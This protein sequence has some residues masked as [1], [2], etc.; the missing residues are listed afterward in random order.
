MTSLAVAIALQART[1][2]S[3]FPKKVLFPIK[4]TPLIIH[5][6]SRL[7]GLNLPIYVLTSDD[8][9]DDDLV[10]LLAKNSVDFF[11]GNLSNV[12]NRFNSFLLTTNYSHVFRIS[13]D[14]PLIHPAL[15][16]QAL[17]LA[18]KENNFDLI[19]NVL[20]RSF[21]KG[22]S[23]ELISRGAL[24]L[25][26]QRTSE[27]KDLEHVTSFFYRNVEK[28]KVINFASDSNLAFWNLCIDT[29][30]D[31]E[32]LNTIMEI[33]LSKPNSDVFWSDWDKFVSVLEAFRPV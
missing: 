23:I 9:T 28:Y 7:K 1:S 27:I 31:L 6:V 24:N 19:T 30:E 18:N 10:D 13:A 3:R 21:P 15:L 17:R 26:E 33:A 11:R 2:S 5:I 8:S 16:M 25:A 22:Q 29:F 32:R 14:S 20:P 12:L 4:G